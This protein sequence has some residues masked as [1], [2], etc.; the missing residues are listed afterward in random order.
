MSLRSTAFSQAGI[1]MK[2]PKRIANIG[3]QFVQKV[4]A[5]CLAAHF[6][7]CLDGSEFRVGAAPG[8]VNRNA[9]PHE[10]LTQVQPRL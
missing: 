8:F 9:R 7:T 10:R 5:D 1:P 4:D 6:L 3:A 2:H